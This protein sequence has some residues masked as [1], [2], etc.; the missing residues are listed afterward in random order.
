M[1]CVILKINSK[2]YS[3]SGVAIILG[4]TPLIIDAS[5]I[6]TAPNLLLLRF[7]FS[8]SFTILGILLGY[9]INLKPKQ[10]FILAFI[11]SF[12]YVYFSKTYI[13]PHIIFKLENTNKIFEPKV[14]NDFYK[15][16]YLN[17]SNDTLSFSDFS[18]NCTIVDFFFVGCAP[19][20]GK[21]KLYEEIVENINSE[22]YKIILVCNGALTNKNTFIEYVN[23]QIKK[24]NILY[25]Y[26]YNG[27]FKKLTNHTGYPFE[28]IFNGT[29]PLYT[30]EGFNEESKNILMKE[31]INQIKNIIK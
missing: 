30:T 5:V 6:F 25:L 27:A 24:D 23:K 12:V 26:D 21:R 9:L 29:I 28:I 17:S 2:E 15:S 1:Y 22:K 10:Y 19:C 3:K 31:K 14:S 8:S 13:I 20:E 16:K 4:A 11:F 7:P 18:K